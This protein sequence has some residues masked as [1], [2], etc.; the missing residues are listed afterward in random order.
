MGCWLK[1]ALFLLPPVLLALWA[2]S[3]GPKNTSS[4]GSNEENGPVGVF[5]GHLVCYFV[6]LVAATFCFATALGATRQYNIYQQYMQEGSAM[7]ATGRVT[8]HHVTSHQTNCIETRQTHDLT[9]MYHYLDEENGTI[10]IYKKEKV[11]VYSCTLCN[12]PEL[13]ALHRQ[14]ATQQS[15]PSIPLRILTGQPASGYPTLLLEEELA[16]FWVRQTFGVLIAAAALVMFPVL[17]LTVGTGDALPAVMVSLAW[18]TVSGLFL[19]QSEVKSWEEST[20]RSGLV[21]E[22]S[23]LRR[24]VV[25]E[26]EVSLPPMEEAQVVVGGS[27][28]E[29]APAAS[30]T[31]VVAG[32]TKDTE[33]PPLV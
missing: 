27:T 13:A 15:L 20:L 10:S 18:S 23:S 4:Y 28:E 3:L 19:A 22:E 16:G 25:R 6:Q 11:V 24:G 32:V 31:A 21:R 14:G 5:F 2:A 30:A 1:L 26:E 8:K 7:D 29:D 12:P 17:L 33:M 9:Y